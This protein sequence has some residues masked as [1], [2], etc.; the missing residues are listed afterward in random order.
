[1]CY[2]H[3][4]LLDVQPASVSAS[5]LASLQQ[6]MGILLLEQSLL[7]SSSEP[8]EPPSKR[9]RGKKELP[10]DTERWIHLA[11]WVRLSAPNPLFWGIFFSIIFHWFICPCFL[12]EFL[13]CDTFR[14][15]RS[16]GDYD[17]VRGIF[18]GKIGTK[19]ITCT[20]LQSEAKGDYAEAVKLY[21]EVIQMSIWLHTV[22]AQF[23]NL[24]KHLDLSTFYDVH[25]PRLI[26]NLFILSIL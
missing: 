8:N 17:V 6:P 9:A 18:G 13:L 26:H 24:I 5:C 21:N 1:M 7:H 2:H 14:L 23:L 25:I 10:P 11:K 22:V 3:S 4:S 12:N 19:S 16:L 15:Y 20:A